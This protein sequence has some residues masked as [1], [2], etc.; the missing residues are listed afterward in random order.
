M[1]SPVL[2]WVTLILACIASVTLGLAISAA[3]NSERA[4]TGLLGIIVVFNLFFSGGV[5]FNERFQPILERISVYAVS[6]WAAEGISISTQLYCWASNPRFQDFFSRG[7]LASVWLFIIVY[8]CVALALAFIALRLQEIWF[9]PRDRLF[10]AIFNEHM[11]ML[12]PMILIAFSWATF[13]KNRS[14]DYY[15]LRAQ[16]DNVRIENSAS[17]NLFQTG[18][19][20][21]SQSLCPL[22]T[23]LPP[24]VTPMV[25]VPPT[26]AADP[27]TPSAQITEAAT[28]PA[29][30]PTALPQ[31]TALPESSENDLAPLPIGVITRE[32]S[33]LFVP[34]RPD[35]P[36]ENLPANSAFILLGK[37]IEASWFRVKELH[38]GRHL[39]GWLPIEAT[40][41]PAAQTGQTASPP[42]CAAPRAYLEVD[43]LAPAAEWNSDVEGHVVAVIDLFRDQ[44]G[45]ETVPSQLVVEINGA[46]YDSYTI[47]VTRQAFV[48][49]GLAV[50]LRISAGDRLGLYLATPIGNDNLHLRASIFF[51]PVGCS[52]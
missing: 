48:F 29:A 2:V 31:I 49:R 51:V 14:L 45:G 6:H 19:G 34:G 35:F 44:A 3:S 52:F 26:L 7:H 27:L 30:N 46:L 1:P 8:M 20:M 37:D 43:G 38:T 22:P 18:V 47:Q 33:I 50:D 24:P 28:L 23:P 4:A 25:A 10:K 13:L 9:S 42:V 12:A 40:N 11:L 5:D 36:L 15:N 16:E 21:I 17:R 32:T 41:L 39:V